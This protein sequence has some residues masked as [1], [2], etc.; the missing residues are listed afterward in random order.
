MLPDNFRIAR[1]DR[2][3]DDVLGNLFEHYLH[4]MAQWFEFDTG[5]DGSYS[6][7]THAIWDAYD[8]YFAYA[9]S[10]PIGFALI[11]SA[12]AW[13]DDSATRDMDE[14][15]VIRRYRRHGVGREFA[16]HLWNQYPGS[17]LVRVMQGN[18]PAL[19]FWREIIAAR[20]G[21]AFKE[22]VRTAN[23][24]VWSYFTFDSSTSSRTIARR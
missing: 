17:W 19:P 11:G 5:T 7:A 6:Y 2:T 24:R 14:F 15:F 20:A 23:E 10:I 13:T 21:G 9:D 12:A 8:V 18:L 16:N 3:A 22:D 4:D 1:V